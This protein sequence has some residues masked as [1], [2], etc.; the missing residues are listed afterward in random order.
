VFQDGSCECP[1]LNHRRRR[2]A[3][4]ETARLRRQARR[5][6]VRARAGHRHRRCLASGRTRVNAC[7][8]RLSY[9]PS[10]R[11]ATAAVQR[12]TEV[13]RWTPA[14]RLD[15]HRTGRD[16]LLREKCTPSA[17]V[18]GRASCRPTEAGD[19]EARVRTPWI[20]DESLRSFIR[21]S[22]VYP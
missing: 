19:I 4:S 14:R 2:R 21:V 18:D 17:D 11:S 1:K 9:R 7:A 10:C 5:T 15:R 12:P 6:D 3:Q 8:V 13:D 22:Q 20:D 16:V